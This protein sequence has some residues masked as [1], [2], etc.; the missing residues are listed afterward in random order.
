MK[1]RR[2]FLRMLGLAPVTAPVALEAAMAAPAA[3]A[4]FIGI[5]LGSALDSP[6]TVFFRNGEPWNPNRSRMY[7]MEK[8][9]YRSFM[10][11]PLNI[12]PADEEPEVGDHGRPVS[13][14]PAA[15]PTHNTA[16]AC[17]ATA[18]QMRKQR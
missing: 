11:R 15:K 5:D 16:L 8:Y 6:D 4:P 1:T 18:R 17:A 2:W 12:W 14:L 9:H 10:T 13:R 7:M 3:A